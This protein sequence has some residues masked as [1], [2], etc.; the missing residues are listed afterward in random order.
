[1]MYCRPAVL[2]TALRRQRIAAPLGMPSLL[3]LFL[4]GVP[5]APAAGQE[6]GVYRTVSSSNLMELDSPSGVGAFARLRAGSNFSV[7]LSF[8][9]QSNSS[10]RTG[11][12][13]TVYIP[14]VDCMDEGVRTDT[15]LKGAAVTGGM[16]FRPL[17]FLEF[18]LGGG[19]SLNHI[20]ARDQTESG[21][22]SS[23]FVQQSAQFG[24]LLAGSARVRPLPVPL[25]IEAGISGHRIS[26][27]G[28][29]SDEFRYDPYCGATT[30]REFRIGIGYDAGW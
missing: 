19:V 22:A 3:L 27:N 26:L 25:T 28:C 17:S 18:E 7:R 24:T 2:D 20:R 5:P 23:L 14:V 30:L 29:A 4:S 8:Q 10:G 12:V 1:M 15:R 9:S 6:V 16:R 11:E 13:C 21:R